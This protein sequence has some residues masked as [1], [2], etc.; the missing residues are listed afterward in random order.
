MFLEDSV[1]FLGHAVGKALW[2]GQAA[3]TQAEERAGQV[4]LVGPRAGSKDSGQRC[5]SGAGGAPRMSFLGSSNLGGEL[6]RTC[7]H[8]L[9]Y[10][11]L[12]LRRW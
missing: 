5:S 6:G 4:G 11:P 9:R 8:A 2:R 12:W 1:R 10:P 7:V 3:G